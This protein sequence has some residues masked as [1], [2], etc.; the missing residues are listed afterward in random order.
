M[1]EIYSTQKEKFPK[2]KLRLD[3][4][5]K[6]VAV[7]DKGDFLATLFYF[8]NADGKMVSAQRAKRCLEDAQY[9]TEWGYWDQDGRFAGYTELERP[10]TSE[11]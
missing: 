6:V 11:N 5:L 7:S 4:D 8:S 3:P 2:P 10:R 1:L 9:S